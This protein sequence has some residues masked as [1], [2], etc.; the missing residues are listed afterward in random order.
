MTIFQILI[1][2]LFLFPI[3]HA[4]SCITEDIFY[5]FL[6]SFNNQS[7]EGDLNG[8]EVDQNDTMDLCRIELFLDYLD[9]RLEIKFSPRLENSELSDGQVRFDTIIVAMDDNRTKLINYLEY[10]CS[11]EECDKDFAIKHISWLLKA[12]Y[13]S[14]QAKASPL[15]LGN[16]KDAG[17]YLSIMLS[18][19]QPKCLYCPASIWIK[20]TQVL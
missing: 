9:Q 5:P 20:F 16:T 4:L 15:L 11:D 12:Q 8:L 19:A 18:K 14:L 3:S 2:L 6:A 7:F 10:A 1:V 13:T 17:K